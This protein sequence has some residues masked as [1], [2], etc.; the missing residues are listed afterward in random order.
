MLGAPHGCVGRGGVGCGTDE[1]GAGG[2]AVGGSGG[3]DG[4]AVGSASCGRTGRGVLERMRLN[5]LEPCG[6]GWPDEGCAR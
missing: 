1:A 2:E 3:G 4:K 6:A 5:L